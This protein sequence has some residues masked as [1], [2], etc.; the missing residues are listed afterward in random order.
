AQKPGFSE[1]LRCHQQIQEKTRF[2]GHSR[3]FRN[4]VL[5]RFLVVT[6]RFR[7]KPGFLGTVEKKSSRLRQ[8]G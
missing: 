2:L 4:R 5:I 1:I 8:K 6:D 3:G 7:K